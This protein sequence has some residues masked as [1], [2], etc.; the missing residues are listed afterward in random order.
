MFDLLQIQEE[1]TVEKL[2]MLLK[3]YKNREDMAVELALYLV[4]LALSDFECIVVTRDASSQTPNLC[5]AEDEQNN[6]YIMAF[7]SEEKI[8]SDNGLHPVRTTIKEL[9]TYVEEHESLNGV[10]INWKS[11]EAVLLDRRYILVLCMAIKQQEEK[12]L[13]VDKTDRS[14]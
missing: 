3:K 5:C 13:N 14:N 7:T 11:A 1:L 6:L 12:V 2:E 8:L 10:Y 4:Q 9:L